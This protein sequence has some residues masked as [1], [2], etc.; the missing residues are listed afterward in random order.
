MNR[1]SFQLFVCCKYQCNSEDR[2]QESSV[3]SSG[4][5]EKVGEQA[6]AEDSPADGSEGEDYGP[7]TYGTEDEA[8]DEDE[9][10]AEDEGPGTYIDEEEQAGSDDS[11]ADENDESDSY[12]NDYAKYLEKMREQNEEG[13]A[14]DGQESSENENDDSDSY[15]NDYAEYLE[16]MR[17]QDEEG[18]ASDGQ[19]SSENENDDSDSYHNDNSEYTEK[20]RKQGVAMFKE[21]KQNPALAAEILQEVLKVY[22]QPNDDGIECMRVLVKFRFC[23][24]CVQVGVMRNLLLVALIFALFFRFQGLDGL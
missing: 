22:E 15:H 13:A 20:M 7:G 16:K 8:E 6:P 11:S 1:T 10:E 12:D 19:E 18:A 24:F 4:E 9:A 5:N 3:D 2:S 14:S 17:E 21:D 23:L